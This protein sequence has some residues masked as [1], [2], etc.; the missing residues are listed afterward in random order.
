MPLPLRQPHRHPRRPRNP[1]HPAQT[2]LNQP[3]APRKLPALALQPRPAPALDPAAGGSALR[4]GGLAGTGPPG[5]RPRADQGPQKD[6][7]HLQEDKLHKDV[8]RVLL[9]RKAVHP[10]VRL[11]WVLQP[12]GARGAAVESQAEVPH[13][14]PP[15]PGLQL[16]EDQLPEEIL[17]VLQRRG[18]LHRCLQLLRLP[19]PGGLEQGGGGEPVR[20]V[21][22]PAMI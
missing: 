16:Q 6:G 13:K 20:G 8:L 10:R 5:G 12:R 2:H 9:S 22:L 3:P 21:L 11:L 4:G 15:H 18:G 7:L 17:R 14:P 19:Q 1:A